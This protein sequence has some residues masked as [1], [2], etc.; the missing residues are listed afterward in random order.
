[1]AR[2][3]YDLCGDNLEVRFSPFCWL[4]K[5]ALR[6]KGL[7]F[8]TV[9]LGFTEK[10]NYPDPDY[11]KLPVLKD[12]DALVRDS[13]EIVA[14][15]D[16][17]YADH[18]LLA[19][20]AAKARFAFYMAFLMGHAM[21]VLASVMSLHIHGAVKPEDRDYYRE[22]REARLG[23]ALEEANQ[24]P[25]LQATIDKVFA[26]LAAPL[27]ACPFFGGT[28]P[29]ASD[30]LVGGVFMWLRNAGPADLGPMPEALSVWYESMLDFFDGYARLSPRASE[31]AA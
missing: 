16:K 21:P 17:T 8:E 9:P 11:G 14:Y 19:D 2:I 31:S 29:D 23:R 24:D 30:Y 5:F 15:L 27:S 22:T 10:E 12:G 25:K 20:D 18:P 3:L 4:A 13:A 6:H 7:D 1:M 26:T 28:A